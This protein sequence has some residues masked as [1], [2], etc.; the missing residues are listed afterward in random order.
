MAE[1]S[2]EKAVDPD[3]VSPWVAWAMDSTRKDAAKQMCYGRKEAVVVSGA[4]LTSDFVVVD[5]RQE[6]VCASANLSDLTLDQV[7]Q[8][9]LP[10]YWQC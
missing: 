4:V 7:L 5:L 8:Q 2:V 3:A 10:V 1:H 6:V 9:P